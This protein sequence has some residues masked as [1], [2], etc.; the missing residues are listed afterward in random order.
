MKKK[1]NPEVN[2]DLEFEILKK[3]IVNLSFLPN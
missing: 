1:R 3:I 2:L